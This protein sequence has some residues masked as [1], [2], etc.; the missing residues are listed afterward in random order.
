MKSSEL[1]NILKENNINCFCGV[2]DSLLKDFC[3]YITD[4]T[5]TKNHTITANEGNAIALASGHYLATG[6]PAVVYMQNSGIGN[7]VNPLLSL[8]DEEVYKIPLLMFIGWRGEPDK[9]DEPQHIKQG[10]VTDKLL[11]A[12]GIKYEILPVDFEEAKT[13]IQKTINYIKEEQVPFAFIVK[14][15]TFEKY[16]LIN[17]VN[18][19][20]SLKREDA[21]ETVIENLNQNDVVI[22]T[23]GHISREVYET[24]N[25]LNQP[26]KQDFL[27]VGS[28]GHASSIALSIALE[29][30]DR[31]IYCFDGDGA[32][33]MHQGA[34]TVNASKNLNNFKHIV[35]NNEAHD[36]VGS[37]PTANSNANLSQIA[38]NSGYKKVYS[39]ST[40]DELEKILPEFLDDN[41]TTFLEIKV[42]C[43]ARDDLGRPK[44]K[45]QENKKIFM[46][47]L[48]QVDFIYRGAIENLYK[49]LKLEKAKKVLVFTGKNSYNSLKPIIEKQLE[50][51]EYN[52]YNDFSTNPKEEEIKIAI[53]KIQKD[54]DLIISVGGGSVIDFA[55]SY[56]WYTKSNKKHIA[57]PTTCGTGSEAT[58]FAVLYVNGVKTSLDNLSIL[59][60]YSIVDSQFVENN[61]HEIKVSC[62]LDAFCQAI[63]SY[64]AVKSTP[65]SREFAKKAMILCRDYLVD[66]I[67]NPNI[68]NSEKIMKASNFAGKA[69]N[70]SRTTAAHALSYV[71]T[72]KYNV[73]HGIAVARTIKQLLLMNLNISDENIAD[74]RGVDFV[75]EN[76]SDLLS[77]FSG[78]LV[79]F[80]NKL[81]IELNIEKYFKELTSDEIEYLVSKINID[82]LKNNPIKLSSVDIKNLYTSNLISE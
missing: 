51:V 25:R 48:N 42:K 80:L 79:E 35:F 64:W 61:P 15:G 7:C 81:F 78:N 19:G 29:K 9:K 75:K 18:S 41:G 8:T 36:S 37:Q 49:I 1:F 24:R 16:S 69:I 56:K 58:Q 17:K 38:L 63:E 67:N 14:K 62:G 10:K 30:Q 73:T 4:N 31:N 65:I 52:Y 59:P 43:G 12:M 66:Y 5:D 28:M 26:H 76:L 32:F 3:A 34:L 11:E 46:E 2:P 55:K 6:N 22:A 13:I 53:D 21:I 47:N 44:E 23:T 20:F 68:E 72:S 33:L 71:L 60:N 54:F 39:V 50:K 77:I 70:I 45:P 40:K 57:I 27:T 82:R 74:K